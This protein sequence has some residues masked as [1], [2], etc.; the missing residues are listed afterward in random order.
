MGDPSRIRITG[1]LEPYASGFA[2]GLRRVGYKCWNC[3][4]G[5]TPSRAT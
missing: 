1:P 2:A 5:F 3:K 4:T